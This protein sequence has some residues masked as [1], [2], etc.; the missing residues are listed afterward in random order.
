MIKKVNVIVVYNENKTEVL[1]CLRT[2]DPYKGLY[3]FVGGKVEQGESNDA[4]AYRELFEETG[5]GRDAIVIAPLYTTWYHHDNL[6]LQV[7]YGVLTKS[8]TLIPE[9]HPLYWMPLSGE[10][11]SAEA[12]F[13]GSGNI[14]HI[15]ACANYELQEAKRFID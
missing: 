10:D 1:M 12:K 11:F 7:Y 15:I 5:I 2:K 8:V 9:K 6:E 13:A 4:A 3:N 14:K